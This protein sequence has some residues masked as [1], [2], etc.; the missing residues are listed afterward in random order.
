MTQKWIRN[1]KS[2]FTL[3]VLI[4]IIAVAVIIGISLMMVSV[5]EFNFSVREQNRI[6]AYYIAR[7]G[8]DSVENWINHPA[9]TREEVQA[10]I[11]QNLVGSESTTTEYGG[12]QF[13][14][15]FG[16]NANQPIIYSTGTYQNSSRAVSLELRK[17]KFL[18]SAIMVTDQL[19]IS[20]PN[21]DVI[22]DISLVN[23]AKE[24]II[25]EGWDGPREFPRQRFTY[26]DVDA[27]DPSELDDLIDFE[28]TDPDDETVPEYQ[29]EYFDDYD[30]VFDTDLNDDDHHGDVI[31]FSGSKQHP[32]VIGNVKI[33][34]KGGGILKI[35]TDYF[36][37]KSNDF[38]CIED[39]TV[40]FYVID[41]GIADFQTGSSN[42][43][44]IIYA[45]NA[46][47]NVSA[48]MEGL[49]AIF[50]QTINLESGA[51][52]EYDE[53]ASSI[54]PELV[55]MNTMGYELYAWRNE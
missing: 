37:L 35:Y 15:Y 41:G 49:T 8:I 53:N 3:S 6:K 9:R 10:L 32:F 23:E 11:D 50:G 45:P 25:H 13:V 33:L 4:I 21:V 26:E 18:A 48:N 1:K 42:F 47:V 51:I 17:R 46:Q 2:G 16:G 38:N 24:P 54:F 40:V 22:G 28:P 27:P 44:A 5:N 29:S 39:T 30:Y 43:K 55:G 7:A 14:L 12:G 34:A 36:T 19:N 52:I 31:Y 20:A